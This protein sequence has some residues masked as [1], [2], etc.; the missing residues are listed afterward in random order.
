[1]EPSE[2]DIIDLRQK[3]LDKI[4]SPE[5]GFLSIIVEEYATVTTIIVSAYRSFVCYSSQRFGT[6]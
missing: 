3:A 2:E 6:T 1:M 4:E 5:S